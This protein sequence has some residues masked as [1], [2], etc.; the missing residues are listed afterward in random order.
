MEASSRAIRNG[1][2]MA[3]TALVKTSRM[4]RP[5]LDAGRDESPAGTGKRYLKTATKL[6]SLKKSAFLR[7]ALNR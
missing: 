7:R 6:A 1:R 4:P 2:R 5:L 3:A